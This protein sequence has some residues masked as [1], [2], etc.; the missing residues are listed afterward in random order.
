MSEGRWE[1]ID[2]NPAT[3]LQKWMDYDPDTDEVLVSYKQDDAAIQAILDRNK[4][5]Q[6]DAFDRSSDMWHAAH[7]PAIVMFEWLTKYGVDAWNPAHRDGVKRLLNDPE[8]R[9]LRVNHFIM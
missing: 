3:G 6:A 4:E 5:A 8:Y 7:I 9:Y 1:L 2:Y